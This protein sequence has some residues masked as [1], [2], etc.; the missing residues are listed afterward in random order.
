MH[1]IQDNLLPTLTAA[2]LAKQ[3]DRKVISPVPNRVVTIG[4]QRTGEI[5]LETRVHGWKGQPGFHKRVVSL[6][7]LAPA[8]LTALAELLGHSVEPER[9][10]A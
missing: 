8:E 4:L 7:E 3:L 9:I 10:A 1:L 2:L 6:A 5:K